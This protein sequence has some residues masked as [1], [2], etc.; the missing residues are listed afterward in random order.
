MPTTL[1]TQIRKLDGK[2]ARLEAASRR[3]SWV[4]LGIILAGGLITWG[5]SAAAG[6]AGGWLAFFAALG[7][8]T[9]VA[10]AHRRLES[11][12]HC[13]RLWRELKTERLARLSLDW[14]AIP[15]PP[16]PAGRA[17]SRL[18][19]DLDL[20]G[21]RSIHRLI[22]LAV[23]Q[24]GSRLLADWLAL[25]VPDL[26]AID[27]RQAVVRELVS[28]ARFRDRLL[29][30]F[31]LV[32]KEALDG[33]KLLRWLREPYPSARL[34][35]AL[36][37]SALFV[38]LNVIL[39]LLN[40]AGRLPPYW[41]ATGLLYAFFYYANAGVLAKFLEAVV[42]LDDELAKFRAI[43]Q[44]LESYPLGERERLAGLCRPFRDP[45]RLPSASLRQVRFVTAAVGLRMNFVMGFLL[46]LVFP[47]DFTFAFL[48]GRLRQRLAEALP[49]W[50][51][52]WNRLE[53]LISLA[54]FASLNP[55]YSF[56]EIA[57]AAGLA[58]A[59]SEPAAPVFAAR[60]LGH[61]L[62]PASQRVCNDFTFQHLGEVAI[63][64]G[65]NMAG[66]STFIK[67]VGV[68]LCLAYAGG[69]VC[70]ASLR[71]LPFRLHTCLRITDSI[72]DGFSYFYAEVKCLKELLLSLKQSQSFPLLY[73][74]D[75]IFR[76]TNNRERLI[77]SRSYIKE[78]IGQKGVGLLAT[79]DLELATLAETSPQ[80]QNYHFRDSVL[81]GKLVF[82]YKIHPGPSPTT[83]ALAIM[84]QEGL[85]VE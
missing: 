44:V 7:V 29:L 12:I 2:I 39:F 3:Y 32:T 60:S 24:E 55:G 76:G 64:T 36:P 14:E 22:S 19:L 31:R 26:D 27:E 82:D 80:V 69:P 9:A 23:S 45:A 74:I 71:C 20:A 61:P 66:K 81:D 75:E 28:L 43:L 65:S 41:V 40:A 68:N 72:S 18:E 67:T 58:M 84:R 59:P 52:A 17:M 51:A 62:I 56:P 10:L 5:A 6:S 63:I 30:A 25:P 34:N 47:W 13:L 70:A 53:A 33:E 85:P 16:L 79:H 35:W 11:W 83:N 78:V 49:A 54:N 1:E 38:A 73:L 21:D 57:P 4:R 77:G 46:N 42:R 48:A 50:F 8:F 15:R 37:V